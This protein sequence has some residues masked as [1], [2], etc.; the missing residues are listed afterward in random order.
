M[1]HYLL[2]TGKRYGVVSLCIGTGMGAAA[3]VENPHARST[4]HESPS[5][6]DSLLKPP[7]V[8]DWPSGGGDKTTITK[9]RDSTENGD[10]E[11]NLPRKLYS[12]RSRL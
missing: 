7:A 3:V 8:T 12:T 10:K 9:E 5:T 6:T 4:A 11:E 1:I 2:R